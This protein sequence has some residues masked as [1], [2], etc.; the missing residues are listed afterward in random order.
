MSWTPTNKAV[1]AESMNAMPER[2]VSGTYG[3]QQ[4]PVGITDQSKIQ[5]FHALAP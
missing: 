4:T 1:Q 3:R 5:R 2:Y